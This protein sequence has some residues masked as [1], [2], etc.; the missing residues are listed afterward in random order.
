MSILLDTAFLTW[1]NKGT[2]VAV[3]LI[4]ALVVSPDG[5]RWFVRWTWRRATF[6]RREHHS[7]SAT[8]RGTGTM[9]AAGYMIPVRSW[10]EDLPTKEQLKRIRGWLTDVEHKVGKLGVDLAKHERDTKKALEEVTRKHEA[11]F[12]ELRSLIRQMEASEARVDGRALPVIGWGI[13]LSGIPELLAKS[14][15]A[16]Y[17][18]CVIGVVATIGVSVSVYR[19]YRR[20]NRRRSSGSP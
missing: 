9:S 3:A 6:W 10:P 20:A 16:T 2:G 17:S 14:A 11:G 15:T 12:Q 19:E 8:L 5:T 1:V 18:L 4:G 7:G 13:L